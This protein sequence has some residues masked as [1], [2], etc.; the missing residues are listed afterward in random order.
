LDHEFAD[1]V[2]TLKSVELYV[3]GQHHG[4]YAAGLAGTPFVALASNSHKI[5]SLLEWAGL[6]FALCREPHD[7]E[8]R[9]S[10]ARERRADFE[11]FRE[12]L[13]QTSV[14]DERD[15]DPAIDD[16]CS[17]PPPI[18]ARAV[19]NPEAF[20]RV[21]GG[22]P[23]I[24]LL[25]G[26]SL[27]VAKVSRDALAKTNG[28]FA[29]VNRFRAVEAPILRPVD[30]R[31][32][33]FVVTADGQ[34]AVQAAE[35]AEFLGDGP[36]RVAIIRASLYERHAFQLARWKS[37]IV[38]VPD[39]PAPMNGFAYLLFLHALTGAS[40]PVFVFGADGVDIPRSGT[41]G[42]DGASCSD[43]PFRYE[44]F[45]A[46]GLT[47]LMLETR[48][49]NAFAVSLSTDAAKPPSVYVVNPSSAVTAFP[50]CDAHAVFAA[51]SKNAS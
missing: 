7:L 34:S 23:L 45:G 51:L 49:L 1:V 46:H 50:R 31:L 4:V 18:D 42:L 14:V 41:I 8:A 16:A 27:D 44:E 17:N 35:V 28:C 32:D 5:E 9:M 38:L 26:P 25:H 40:T 22:R 11:R 37:Q 2:E 24:V 47:D 13:M 10:V 43:R 21:V 19:V 48:W 6:Q 39:G 12:F 29:T 36:G 3:T 15:L 30:R 20:A 33:V